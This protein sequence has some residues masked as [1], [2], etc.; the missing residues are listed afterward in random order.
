MINEMKIEEAAN[1]HFESKFSNNDYP[2]AVTEI[3]EQSKSDFKAGA[4]WAINEFLK[5]LWH[6][7]KEKPEDDYRL[8]VEEEFPHALELGMYYC[9]DEC[10]EYYGEP[11]EIQVAKQRIKRWLYVDDLLPKE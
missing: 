11:W 2:I 8:L 10:D 5:D 3:K 1:K 6:D 9:T 4:H 7:A